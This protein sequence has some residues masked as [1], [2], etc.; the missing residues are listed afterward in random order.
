LNDN[1]AKDEKNVWFF[2]NLT[3]TNYDILNVSSPNEFKIIDYR[4]ASDSKR[5]FFHG[6][7]ISDVDLQSYQILGNNW[8]KD[9][10]N[11]YYGSKLCKEVDYDTFEV[12]EDGAKDKNRT[13]DRNYRPSY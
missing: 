1:Y 7:L 6:D 10:K 8:S 4:Y 3:F 13:Y 2:R 5:V 12:T 9:N 11:I